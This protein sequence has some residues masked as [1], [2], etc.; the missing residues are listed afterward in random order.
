MERAGQRHEGGEGVANASRI[1]G[2]AQ[3]E[4]SAG[5]RPGSEDGEGTEGQGRAVMGMSIPTPRTW[6]KLGQG[7]TIG[8]GATVI[9]ST[10]DADMAGVEGNG[11]VEAGPIDGTII[12]RIADSSSGSGAGEDAAVEDADTRTD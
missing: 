7:E 10:A 9:A 12:A 1:T 5:A 4:L 6:D 8:G 3:E 2:G 11:S